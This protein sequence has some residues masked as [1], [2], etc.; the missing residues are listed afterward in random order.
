MKTTL[1]SGLTIFELLVVLTLI[2]AVA[3]IALPRLGRSLEGSGVR[4]AKQEIAAAL[5]NARAVAIQNGAPTTF[6]RSGNSIRVTLQLPSGAT[7]TIMPARDMYAL[8]GVTI[9]GLET[10]RYNPRG[11][12]YGLGGEM[13]VIRFRRG[14]KR[15]SLCLMGRGKVMTSGCQ[16]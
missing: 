12:A 16:L 3:A 13:A 15:D 7:Q 2:G 8:H 9:A 11:N 10:M 5:A 14:E 6:E 4:S 1:R